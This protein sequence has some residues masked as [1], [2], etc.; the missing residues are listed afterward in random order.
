MAILVLRPCI[1]VNFLDVLDKHAGSFF[2]VVHGGVAF[3]AFT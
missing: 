2:K 1:K 3:V